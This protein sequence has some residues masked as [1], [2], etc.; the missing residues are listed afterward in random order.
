[1][2][3]YLIVIFVILSI[4]GCV[5]DIDNSKIQEYIDSL[6]NN[7]NKL[8]IS[9][10]FLK[11]SLE[12]VKNENNRFRDIVGR[13]ADYTKTLN[14]NLKTYEE[15]TY[16]FNK[17]LQDT[18]NKINVLNDLYANEAL[19]EL[20]SNKGNI[21]T[22]KIPALAT[23]E[24]V[25]VNESD[26]VQESSY[27]STQGIIKTNGIWTINDVSYK[28]GNVMTFR[29]IARKKNSRYKILLD[30]ATYKNTH[31]EVVSTSHIDGY[32]LDKNG[33]DTF[34]YY[35]RERSG[36]KLSFIQKDTKCTVVLTSDL[37][38]NLRK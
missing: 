20:T 35:V 27:N 12:N 19:I 3:K 31:N 18:Q 8:Q 13:F 33:K 1:M 7:V 34:S 15:N 22:N 14:K 32:L 9:N 4:S 28:T 37:N 16:K 29:Y 5:N 38:L 23:S 30:K 10:N 21:K 26:E 36:K 6:E 24:C 2:L 17:I 11:Q 25:F